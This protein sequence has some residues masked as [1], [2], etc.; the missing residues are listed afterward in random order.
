MNLK[1]A[2]QELKNELKLRNYSPQTVDAYLFVLRDFS[3]FVKGQ[4]LPLKIEKIRQYLLLKHEQ[5]YS[6][7]SINIR[8]NG[9]KF[10]YE[11]IIKTSRIN[12]KSTKRSKKLPVILSRVEIQKLINN[13]PNIKHQLL[14]SLA[15]GAGLRVSEVNSLRVNDVLL[16]ELTIMIRDAKGKKDRQTVFPESLRTKFLLFLKDKK[17]SDY[18][19]AGNNN[20]KLTVRTLQKIFQNS[21]IQ[22]K[23][24]KQATF[25]SLRHSFA[26]HL[27]ENGVDL[28]YIQSLLGHN[29]IRTTQIYTQITNYGF[30]NIKS[31]L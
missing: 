24:N 20:Q 13:T 8:L 22:S 28:R 29:N 23:I 16:D 1:T 6:P 4:I 19:F 18:L 27:L 30:K 25:H 5:K 31:P 9:L 26:T 12:I 14:L 17:K 10:F 3:N 7:Q 15:Y 2:E 11:Q 21:L